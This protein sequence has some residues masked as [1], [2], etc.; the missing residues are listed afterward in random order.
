MTNVG[1]RDKSERWK[2]EGFE[3]YLTMSELCRIVKRDNS[4]IRSLEK[5]A[6]AGKIKFPSPIRVKVGKLS[7]RLYSPEEVE[8]V[9]EW[10][11]HARPGPRRQPTRI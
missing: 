1:Q 9:K 3:H 2:P 7:V 11:R 5:D 10:F 8:Q 6:A 4:R